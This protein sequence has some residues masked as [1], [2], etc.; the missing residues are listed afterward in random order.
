M[1]KYCSFAALNELF[2]VLLHRTNQ[3][4]LSKKEIQTHIYIIYN[5][6]DKA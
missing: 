4:N 1:V 5:T 2:F 3:S 6:H